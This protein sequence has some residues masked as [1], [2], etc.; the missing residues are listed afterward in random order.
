MRRRIRVLALAVFRSGD[1][2]LVGEGY[3]RVEDRKFYRPLGGAVEFGE[4]CRDA[5]AREIREELDAEI[6]GETLLGVLENRFVYRGEPGHEIVFLFEARLKD[7]SFYRRERIEVRETDWGVA[8]WRS[9]GYFRRGRA[10][11]YPEGLLELLTRRRPE[12]PNR[13]ARPRAG[14]DRR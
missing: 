12:R 1:R 3:D 6:E 14:S 4:S 13:S 2:V 7:R 9:L 11:L 8:R 10:P 5:L